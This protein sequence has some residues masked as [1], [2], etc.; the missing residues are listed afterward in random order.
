[1]DYSLVSSANSSQMAEDSV[2]AM[3]DRLDRAQALDDPSF[4]DEEEECPEDE[5]EEVYKGKPSRTVLPTATYRSRSAPPPPRRE[6]R[7]AAVPTKLNT[8]GRRRSSRRGSIDDSV[9]SSINGSQMA[10]DSVIAMADRLDR[11][12]VLDDPSCIEGATDVEYWTEGGVGKVHAGAASAI[13]RMY[14]PKRTV[15]RPMGG[16][17]ES[18]G[19]KRGRGNYNNN[20]GIACAF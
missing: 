9:I 18:F 3:A 11:A 19:T 5:G 6:F 15:S 4:G 8:N 14:R 7:H 10:E 2:I 16:S 1:M 12:Q 13:A 20:C 17:R